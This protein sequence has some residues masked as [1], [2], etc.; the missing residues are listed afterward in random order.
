[1]LF[2]RCNSFGIGLATVYL[3]VHLLVQYCSSGTVSTSS[4]VHGAPGLTHRVHLPP[5][6]SASIE[7]PLKDTQS[8]LTGAEH[9]GLSLSAGLQRPG[10][11]SRCLPAAVSCSGSLADLG[12]LE[13]R[14]VPSSCAFQPPLRVSSRPLWIP[15]AWRALHQTLRPVLHDVRHE[16]SHESVLDRS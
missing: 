3:L 8:L 7:T 14:P 16:S 11:G 9:A 15:L 5:L 6:Q 2:A 10:K 4:S 13:R 12:R 1:M